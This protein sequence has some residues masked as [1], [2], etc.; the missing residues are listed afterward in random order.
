MPYANS[1]CRT[2]LCH[3]LFY[4]LCTDA[5]GKLRD[6]SKLLASRPGGAVDFDQRVGV[7]VVAAALGV[8]VGD[9]FGADGRPTAFDRPGSGDCLSA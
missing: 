5:R 6:C 8:A 4:C 3:Y 7:A 9:R 1:K 2:G